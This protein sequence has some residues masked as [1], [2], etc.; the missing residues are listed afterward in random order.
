MRDDFLIFK[1]II[2]QVLHEDK[3]K[4]SPSISYII[5]NIC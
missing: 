3:L 5:S 2:F 4:K 1:K